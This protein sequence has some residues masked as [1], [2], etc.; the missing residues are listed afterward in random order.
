MATTAAATNVFKLT[1]LVIE[2]GIPLP[3]SAR[4]AGTSVM[5]TFRAMKVGDSVLLPNK[6]NSY[7][8]LAPK[9]F[10]TRKVE[11]GTRVWRTK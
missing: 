5:A 10:I 2:K 6:N 3:L 8:T 4:C 9:K 11:G 1:R 7:T